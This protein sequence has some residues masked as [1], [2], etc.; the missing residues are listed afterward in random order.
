MTLAWS[1]TRDALASALL[2][3]P[4]GDRVAVRA[5][6]DAL[7]TLGARYDAAIAA[8][9]LA[10]QSGTTLATIT[11]AQRAAALA[12]LQRSTR[13]AEQLPGVGAFTPF[14][15]GDPF[16]T[17]DGSARVDATVSALGITATSRVP[18]AAGNLVSLVL[19]RDAEG[20]RVTVRY[21]GRDA[22]TGA[23][24]HG[25]GNG[26][27]SSPSAEP[28]AGIRAQGTQ[29]FP[30]SPAP[31]SVLFLTGGVGRATEGAVYRAGLALAA[32]EQRARAVGLSPAQAVALALVGDQ[33][34]VLLA[35]VQTSSVD[36]GSVLERE[37][38]AAMDRGVALTSYLAVV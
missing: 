18:G 6:L 33:L 34:R 2:T 12:A 8:G 11:E 38:A 32:V 25:D 5:A 15:P 35:A 29:G 16:G 4:Q 17:G 7:N 13:A 23:R 21:D 26:G 27:S 20:L 14:V 1:A 3:A 19:W 37:L 36:A 9:D 10:P 31:P 30:A 28:L 24:F 22:I